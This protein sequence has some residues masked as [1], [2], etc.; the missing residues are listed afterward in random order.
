MFADDDIDGLAADAAGIFIF[1]FAPGQAVGRGSEQQRIVAEA[2]GHRAGPALIEI[3]LPDDAAL[4][5]RRDVKRQGV[6]VVH[7][8][9]VAA[10][11]DPALVDV[12]G[13]D[14]MGGAHVAAAVFFMPMGH[15][16]RQQIDVLAFVNIFHHRAA[17]D[18]PRRNIGRVVQTLAPG[19]NEVIAVVIEGQMRR[20]TLA[21]ERLMVHADEHPMAGRIIL[22]LVEQDRRIG[23]VARVNFR[24][25]AHL[26]FPVAAFDGAQL[27]ELVDLLHPAA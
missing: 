15:R 20:Q 7:H 8:D 10:D 17:V 25:R 26:I 14:E 5:S 9:A 11:V 2:D 12:A 4:F 19:L 27:A 6:F 16:Q 21:L 22:D 13:D 23:R 24:H 1:R 18:D 3:F